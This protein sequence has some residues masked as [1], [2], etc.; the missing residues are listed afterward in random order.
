MARSSVVS[1]PDMGGALK[2]SGSG[3]VCDDLMQ[4]RRMRWL[5][6]KLPGLARRHRLVDEVRPPSL[7]EVRLF[8]L[9]RRRDFAPVGPCLQSEPF[10]VAAEED[11][12]RRLVADEFVLLRPP[13][14]AL[15]ER[16]P[17]R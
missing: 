3:V 7:A 13:A 14:E 9:P 16:G 6:I 2:E 5:F 15:A 12:D 4:T 8:G 11:V 17:E 10:A 1:L